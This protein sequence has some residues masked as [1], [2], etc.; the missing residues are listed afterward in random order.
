M[1]EKRLPGLPASRGIAIGPV[2]RFVKE[3]LVAKR[4]TAGNPER[5]IERLEKALERTGAQ[6]ARLAERAYRMASKEEAAIFEA[7]ALILQ[8]PELIDLVKQTILDE[9]LNTEYA[10]QQGAGHY[11]ELLRQIE[12]EYL[13]AR[14]GDVE[15]VSQAM[16]LELQGIST[17]REELPHACVVV[18]E[19]L[20]P[21]DTITMDR[22]K[23]LAFCTA[24]GGSTSHVAILAR[25]LGI[26][27]VV[28]LGEKVDSLQDGDAVVVDGEAGLLILHP[29]TQTLQEYRRRQQS[30]LQ[31]QT[32]ALEEAAL[33]AMTP[34]GVKV[35]V[36]ANIGQL[37]EAQEA[38]DNGAEGVG[39]LRTE[40]L[41]LE[42]QTPPGED[43][44][45]QVYSA[46]LEKMGP[47]PVIVRTLDIGGDKPAPYLELSQEDNP[48]LGVRGLRLSLQFPDLFETQ[49]RA[50]LLAGAG[51]DLRIMF[52][53]VANL[54]ELLEA[55]RRFDRACAEL[56]QRGAEFARDVQIGIMVEI[57]SAALMAHVM[58]EHVDFFSI[59]TNDLS[60]YTLAADRGNPQVSSMADA[61]HPAVLRL[62]QM[63]VH[64]AHARGRWVGLCGELAGDPLAA[65]LLLGLGLDELS[66]ASRAIPMVKQAIRHTRA[67]RA[68]KFVPHI[69]DLP[70]PEAVRRYLAEVV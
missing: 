51:H 66:M 1:T 49:L 56:Q 70:G 7:Q 13:A 32:A 10:W 38:I 35:D 12:D 2:F 62:I 27:A 52:P 17:R 5:E 15:D 69:L 36:Q 64:A 4:E 54:D 57:P 42:R 3:R 41:F 23:V 59:G 60:Q 58:A 68:R 44:Q 53:M 40:F 11:A 19:D 24:G 6:F 18:A 43:E 8:D 67:E 25:A 39:L 46:I 16:L 20:A 21:S 47:R 65:P 37:E 28:G 9:R 26:P 33:P 34:D 45:A 30:L 55:R 61:Y 48:F 50:L 63:V 31:S 29:G 22:D 14:A